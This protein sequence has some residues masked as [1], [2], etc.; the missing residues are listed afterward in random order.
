MFKNKL[1]IVADDWEALEVYENRLSS[2]FNVITAAFGKEGV[3][4]AK[5]KIPDVIFVDLVFEDMHASEFCT[6]LRA[7]EKTANI[8]ILVVLNK[9]EEKFKQPHFPKKQDS[10]F[11]RPYLF[12]DL[13]LQLKKMHTIQLR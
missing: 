11:V 2:D 7:E 8:P 10:V 5:E 9:D 12:E 3:K 6:L 1:L 4:A 13:V